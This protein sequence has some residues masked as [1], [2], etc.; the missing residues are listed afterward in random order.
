VTDP[1]DLLATPLVDA[2]TELAGSNS[3]DALL[4]R[5]SDLSRGDYATSLALRLSKPVRRPP[6][7]IAEA[8]RDAAAGSR[9]VESAEVAGPGFLNLRVSPAWYAAAV[10]AALQDGFGGG[11]AE[12]PL[13]INV[14]YVSA[15]P[16]G[17]LTIG[18]AR[19]GAYG[20]S[21]ARLYDFAGHEV[22]REYYFNDAG[23]Q[24]DRFARTLQARTRGEEVPEDGYPGEDVAELAE[25]LDLSPDA[26]LDE[27]RVQGIEAMLAEIKGSL[28]RFRVHVDVFTN[29]VELHQ[30]G[31]VEQAMERVRASGHAFEQD[32]ALWLRTTDFGDDKDRVIVRQNGS[33]TYY[34][35]DLAYLIH[36]MERGYDLALYVLGADHHGYTARLRAAASV[37]GYDPGRVDVP[38]YQMVSISEAGEARKISKRRGDVIFLDDVLDAIGVDATRFF[39]VQRSHDQPIEID[40]ELATEQSSQNPVFYVQYAHARIASIL[41]RAAE[42]SGAERVIAASPL[43]LEA[44]VEPSERALV[45]RVASF[46]GIARAA[47]DMRAPHRIV[48]YAHE[49]AAD[50]HIFYRDCPVLKAPTPEL[51]R[52]RLSL[53]EATR[54]TLARCLDL[55]GVSAPDAM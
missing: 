55:V 4:E 29:E 9:Y 35:A 1:L 40:V 42:E 21:L 19:N 8:L 20:D 24:V 43:D 39:L 23:S 31:L 16:T 28:E 11:T 53:C 7:E 6:R 14:E 30:G 54:R 38:L 46:P 47:A 22:T 25:R 45:H 32:G 26:P 36:K 18:S 12:K 10:Q 13:K 33:P 41:R 17:R 27:F 34:A 49:L 3:H 50:Y 5:P 15:N 2:A 48:A 52:A 37:L 44:L 51:L